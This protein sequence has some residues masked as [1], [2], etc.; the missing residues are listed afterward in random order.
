MLATLSLFFR[1]SEINELIIRNTNNIPAG[2][3]TGQK[4]FAM[5]KKTE[6]WVTSVECIFLSFRR[7]RLLRLIFAYHFRLDLGQLL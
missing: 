4:P 5:T 1:E 7:W 3:A 2:I 6:A